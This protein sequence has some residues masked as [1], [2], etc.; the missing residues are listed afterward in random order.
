MF[1]FN[2]SAK[3][4]GAAR[5]CEP[6]MEE[7]RFRKGILPNKESISLCQLAARYLMVGNKMKSKRRL[8]LFLVIA[9]MVFGAEAVRLLVH[10][11]FSLSRFGEALLER[12]PEVV[13][14]TLA[15]YFFGPDP[16]P[17]PDV[18]EK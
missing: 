5:P 9:L 15:A 12:L 18:A 3:S 13:V 2:Q 4:I 16:R 8:K 6:Q 14:F 1:R 11:A 17:L 7:D 10:G